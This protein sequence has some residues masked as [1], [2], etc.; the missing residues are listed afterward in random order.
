VLREV[1]LES[2]KCFEH[3]SL[4]VNEFTLLTGTNASGKSSIIQALLLLHQSALDTRWGDTLIVDGSIVS[5]GT[6]GDLIDEVH[7]RRGFQLGL[8]GD[9]FRARWSFESERSD[10]RDIAVP[11]KE[12][13]FEGRNLDLTLAPSL[14][15]PSVR[16]TAAGDEL[17]SLLE[18]LGYVCADRIGPREVYP[19]LD[20]KRHRTVGAQGDLAAGLLYWFGDE[21]EVS[22][23]LRLQ[24]PPTLGRQAEAWLDS[25]FPGASYEVRPVS[26][27]NLV[28]L[29]FRTSA[30]ENFHRPQ[31][32]GFGLSH[33][34]PILVAVLSAQA[35]ST[36]RGVH[37]NLVVVENPEV[38]L[39]PD[40]QAKMGYFLARAAQ[41]GLQVIVETHSDHV[42]NGARRAV[43]DGILAPDLVSMHFFRPR[44]R[45]TAADPSQVI[46]PAMDREGRIDHWPRGFFDQHEKDTG[47]LAGL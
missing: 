9:D 44:S 36:V 8:R 7:G 33:V 5:L 3:L 28:T 26:G 1:E 22:E 45:I 27:A 14:L 10:K 29:G 11:I 31:N 35:R 12:A 6:A 42:L 23:G 32:V 34:F 4:P 16:E 2:F 46:S 40:G 39:H 17:A 18:G 30:E 41:C 21:R 20:P 43:R 25:F 38:H 19:L 37:G 24:A 47:Y 13:L 15:P